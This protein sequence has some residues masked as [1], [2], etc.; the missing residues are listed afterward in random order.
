MDIVCPICKNLNSTHQ[1]VSAIYKS[2]ISEGSY[3]GPSHVVTTTRDGHSSL[4]T[5]LATH[6][7]SSQTLLSKQLAPP[8][9]PEQYSFGFMFWFFTVPIILIFL[10]FLLLTIIG[11]EINYFELGTGFILLIIFLIKF[12]KKKIAGK[13]Y[14][15]MLPIWE[16]AFSCWRQLYYCS[17]HDQVFNPT[18]GDHFPVDGLYDYLYSQ[19]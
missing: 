16:K 13:K 14:E 11:E 19:H 3:I 1:K 12:R 6:Y 17:I 5:G 8:K 7:G 2:G 18:T 15:K 10:F 4:S 9:K